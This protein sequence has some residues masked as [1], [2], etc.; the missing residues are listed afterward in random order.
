M[1]KIKNLEW[2]EEMFVMSIRT[3]IC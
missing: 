3:K 2:K 1:S